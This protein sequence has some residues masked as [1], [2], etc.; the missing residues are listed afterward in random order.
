MALR[1]PKLVNDD[2]LWRLARLCVCN[3]HGEAKYNTV[4]KEAVEELRCLR[5]RAVEIYEQWNEGQRFRNQVIHRLGGVTNYQTNSQIYNQV[6]DAYNAQQQL[7]QQQRQQQ[8]QQQTTNVG[9]LTDAFEIFGMGG[10]Q[11][12]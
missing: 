9:Q 12:C 5:A 4:L 6:G 2:G 1:T 7:E 11:T 3:N 8:E 10:S